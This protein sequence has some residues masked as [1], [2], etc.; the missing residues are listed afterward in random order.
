M[1]G[2]EYMQVLDSGDEDE[3]SDLMLAKEVGEALNQEYPNHPW[4]VSFQSHGM[5]IRHLA[6]AGE[7]SMKIGRDGFSAL[8]P[9]EKLGT[10]KEVVKTAREFGGQLLEAFGLKRGPWDGSTPQVPASWA[11]KKSKGFN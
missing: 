8:L 2:Y 1:I 3:A 9:R 10:P 7:V 11:H 6:I 4:V 5:V